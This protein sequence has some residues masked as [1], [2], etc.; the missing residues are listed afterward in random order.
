MASATVRHLVLAA[1]ALVAVA[2]RAEVPAALRRELLASGDVVAPLGRVG[3]FSALLRGIDERGRLLVAA[4]L[5]D[6]SAALYWLDE[7]SLDALPTVTNHATVF[8][9]TSVSSPTGRI[10]VRGVRP[11]ESSNPPAT[12]FVLDSD[13]PRPL[14]S[15]GDTTVEGLYVVVMNELAAIADD[16]TVIVVAGV[17]AKPGPAL[18]EEW[19]NAIVA[20]DAAGARVVDLLRADGQTYPIGVTA[21]GEVVLNAW[22]AG[23]PAAIYAAGAGG[24]RRLVGPGDRLPNGQR[25]REVGGLAASPAGEVLFRGCVETAAEYAERADCAIYRTSG[26][27]MVEVA[28]PDDRTPDGSLFDSWEGFINARGDVVL[29]AT[30]LAPCDD[31]PGGLCDVDW[32]LLYFPVPGGVAEVGRAISGGWLNAAGAVATM[33]SSGLGRWRA[34][35]VATLLRRGDPAP[36]GAAFSAQ[37]IEDGW[38]SAIC[39]ADDGRVGAVASFVDGGRAVV[40]VDADGPHA[41]LGEHDPRLQDRGFWPRVQCD[42]ADGDEM[43][44]GVGGSVFRATTVAGVEPVIGP[45]DVPVDRDYPIGWWFGEPDTLQLFSV[46]RHGTVVAIDR[47]EILRR[48]RDGPLEVVDI[49]VPGLAEVFEAEVADDDSILATVRLWDDAEGATRAA[50]RV[51]H[52]NDDGV[53]LIARRGRPHH[54]SSAVLAG[55]PKSLAVA[56]RLAAFSD[57]RDS[58]PWPLLYDL[59]GSVLRE[60]LAGP[61][62]PA[63]GYLIDLAADGSVLLDITDYYGYGRF[64]LDGTR[65]TRL[66]EEDDFADRA[67]EPLALGAPGV[68]LFRERQ[69]GRQSL[70]VSGAA[71]AIGRC[72]RV[73]VAALPIPTPTATVPLPRVDHDGCTAVAPHRSAWWLLA[74]A[75]LLACARPARRR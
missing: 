47:D 74:A 41:V 3:V 69:R 26:G 55:P 21:A 67:V 11:G 59:D 10:A 31:E 33:T 22:S 5:S 42:F 37:G 51:V 19:N 15:I 46:N 4:D 50:A 71:P 16:G 60:L 48:R 32:G 53:R 9:A 28:G 64:L 18:P 66:S 25:L 58:W 6:G 36:G 14:L 23:E 63:S 39:I 65:L 75:A 68:V 17:S 49:P 72:P 13:G 57:D 35:R 20:I 56:G 54:R 40:C 7:H 38:G 34:G 8:P 52:V 45:D 27:R 43:Y 73:E 62:L 2:S 70:S 12:V 30:W 61:D 44:V 1:L 24:A 29:R